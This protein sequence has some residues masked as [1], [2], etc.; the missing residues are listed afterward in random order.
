MWRVVGLNSSSAMF[1]SLRVARGQTLREAP[2]SIRTASMP[3]LLM[4][5]VMCKGAALRDSS[6]S[7]LSEKDMV[8]FKNRS[9]VRRA[10]RSGVTSCET[11]VFSKTSKRALFWVFECRMSS[12]I[13]ILAGILSRCSIRSY[14]FPVW[15]FCSVG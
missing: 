13:E 9:S 7:S 15:I 3:L 12:R 14:S 5:T 8:G 6:G 2:V 11:L 10:R 1:A 4:R